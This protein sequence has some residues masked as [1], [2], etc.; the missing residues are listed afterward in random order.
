M[1]WGPLH[2]DLAADAENAKAP[3]F[4]TK[5]QDSLSMSWTGLGHMWLN[6]PYANIGDWA[7]K[8]AMSSMSFAP[9]DM[10]FMLVPA[11]VGSNWYW[12]F[13]N[14]YA[15]TCIITP[16]LK[17]IG[18]KTCYPKDLMLAVYHGFCSAPNHIERSPWKKVLDIKDERT[19]LPR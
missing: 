6:P 1:V 11:S 5:E 3:K 4:H 18:H 16:R 8:A 12:E 13:V 10:L 14:G 15:E 17:F 9:G 7:E 19:M 2:I